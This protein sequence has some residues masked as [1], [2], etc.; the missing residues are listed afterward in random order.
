MS[1]G[2]ESSGSL[3]KVFTARKATKSGR[4]PIPNSRYL[5]G[6]GEPGGSGRGGGADAPPSRGRGGGRARGAGGR[7]RGAGGRARGAGRARGGGDVSSDIPS[8]SGDVVYEETSSRDDAP[9]S[10]DDAPESRGEGTESRDQETG[11]SASQKKPKI[12]GES[13]VPPE[14]KEPATEE[15][16]I[17][18]T[19]NGIE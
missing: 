15:E 4:A 2:K 19:P 18:I 11:S 6:G 13:M 5:E 3:L 9:E 14:S 12:R 17:L 1:S 10:R 16:K 8:A 7:A